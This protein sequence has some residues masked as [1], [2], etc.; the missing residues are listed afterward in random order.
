VA[1][2][3][4]FNDS[5]AVTGHLLRLLEKVGGPLSPLQLR[6]IMVEA[7]C[8]NLHLK[9]RP[10]YASLVDLRAQTNKVV[11]ALPE[12]PEWHPVDLKLRGKL[13]EQSLRTHPGSSFVG[14]A[15]TED[16]LVKVRE[17][18]QTFLYD[19][20]GNFIAN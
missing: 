17:G 6:E 4:V 15:S 11:A 5:T 2:V 9:E 10:Q 14:Y 3:T 8:C 18:L 7:A 19:D 12:K 1:I 13:M 20:D 16:F